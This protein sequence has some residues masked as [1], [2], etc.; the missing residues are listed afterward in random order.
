MKRSGIFATE[1]EKTYLQ[2]LLITAKTTPVI[3]LSSRHA[4][5]RG[6]F[7]GEAW[8]HLRKECHRV[9]LEHGLPEIEGYYGMDETGEFV[10]V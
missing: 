5:E 7:S 2:G 6:G 3:A 8:N 9:A 10:T 1:E 4:L